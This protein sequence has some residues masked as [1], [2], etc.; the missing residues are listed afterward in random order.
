MVE[1]G[2]KKAML[3]YDNGSDVLLYSSVLFDVVMMG[4]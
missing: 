4:G 2:Q 3:L 1:E